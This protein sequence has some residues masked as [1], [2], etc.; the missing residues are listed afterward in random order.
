MGLEGA[1]L[2]M[3]NRLKTANPNVQFNLNVDFSKKS[4]DIELAIYRVGQEAVNNAIKHANPTKI[5]VN[6]DEKS[7]LIQLSIENDGQPPKQ[8]NNAGHFGI[9]GMQERAHFLGGELSFE[10]PPSGG[11]IVQ[12]KIPKS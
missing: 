3:F 8:L 2:D 7:Q 4:E 1:L 12:L 6:L 5:T 9:E 11:L 10:M